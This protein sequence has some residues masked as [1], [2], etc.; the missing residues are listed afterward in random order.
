MA[1]AFFIWRVTKERSAA[2]VMSDLKRAAWIF[3]IAAACSLGALTTQLASYDQVEIAYVETFKRAIGLIGAM[4]A[5]Y[6]LFGERDV[7]RRLL[8][9][10][11]M[12]IGVSFILLLR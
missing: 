11:V 12:I 3:P 7:S 4:S 2:L 6:L 8:G 1:V 9:A 10:L 5:G